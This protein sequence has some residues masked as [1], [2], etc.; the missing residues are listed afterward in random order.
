MSSTIKGAVDALKQRISAAYT[1]ISSKGGTLPS[2][3]NS[4]NLPTAIASIPSGGG[5]ALDLQQDITIT[6]G[7]A[8][9]NNTGHKDYTISDIVAQPDL[10]SNMDIFR[11]DKATAIINS[12][13]NSK[14]Y[15]QYAYLTNVTSVPADLFRNNRVIRYIYA[16]NVVSGPT[17]IFFQNGFSMRGCDLRSF[18]RLNMLVNLSNLSNFRHFRLKAINGCHW[19][20]RT[21]SPNSLYDLHF[22]G[23]FSQSLSLVKWVPNDA[24]SSSRTNLITPDEMDDEN[25]PIFSNNLGKL[26]WY[27]E[28]HFLPAFPL[29]E[30]N[31]VLTLSTAMYNVISNN[32]SIEKPSKKL[33]DLLTDNGWDVA[34]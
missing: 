4:A 15:P 26:L 14:L 22:F 7:N 34:S 25:Q 29:V 11:T 2:I 28:Y 3:Q 32:D 17:N 23:T 31:P 20:D 13:F 30:G 24:L 6:S 9:V 27:I 1:A 16:P 10:L 19:T 33:K 5:D 8:I 12:L 18:N 21:D